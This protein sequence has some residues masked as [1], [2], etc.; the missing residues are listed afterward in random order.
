MSDLDHTVYIPG[1]VDITRCRCGA[2]VFYAVG[3][4]NGRM[5]SL[6][7]D[8]S[9]AGKYAVYPATEK[10]GRPISQHVSVA[11]AAG[12]RERGIPIY[13][14]H[15]ESCPKADEIRRAARARR[16]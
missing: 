11:K 1:G 14:S 13:H 5:F 8:P 2:K 16:A 12:M 4:H 6:D 7:V 3:Q 9:P 15:L 10:R